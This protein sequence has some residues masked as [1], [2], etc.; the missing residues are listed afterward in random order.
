MTYKN[1][2]IAALGLFVSISAAAAEP[3]REE[4]IVV[5][6]SRDPAPVVTLGSAVTVITGEMIKQRQA[7]FVTDLLRDVPGFAVSR[8][9]A[10]GY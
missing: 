6:A 7:V 4:S 1:I 3:I 10:V 5:T 2:V 8:S 9:G